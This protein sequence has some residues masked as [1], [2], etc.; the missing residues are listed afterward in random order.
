VDWY[1]WSPEAFEKAKGENKPIFLSIGYSSC[2]WCHVM[3]KEC[4]E[5]QEVAQLLNASFVCIK[6]DREERPDLDTAY[7]AVCQAMGRN[8]GWPLSILMTPRL[9]PFFA[10][11]YIPKDSRGGIVGMM[12]LLPQITQ[13]W[14]M[15]GNQ[16]DI[17]G[18]EIKSR[19]EALEK[20]TPEN[21]LGKEVLA[22]AYESLAQNYDA[23]HG[24]FG[25]APKFPRP[26]SLL[27]LLHYWKSSGTKDALDMVEKTLR[28]MRLGGIFDQVGFGFHRYSTDQVWLV[29]HFE[30][31]LYDQAL[32]AL[33]YT[34]M[35]QASGAGKFKLTA[36]ETLDYVL[37]DLASPEGGF[38]SAQ[39]A[40]VEGEEGKVYL[41]T[42]EEVM[43]TLEP[44]DADLAVHL[45]GLSAEGN[46]VDAAVGRRN[47]KNILHL[48]EP[49]DEIT[50]A[51]G[52]TLDELIIRMGK[53]RNVLFEARK[54]RVPP[55]TDVKVLTD[56]NGL[57]VAALAKA[58]KVLGENRFVEAARKTAN[59]FLAQ[60]R[61][62]NGLLYHRYAGGERAIGGF[63][64]DYAALVFGLIELYEATFEDKYLQAAAELTKKM[65]QQFWD[66]KN[67]GYYFTAA[68][69]DAGMPR[70]KQ[71]Y[72]GAV[73]SGNSM[74]LLNLL[75][76]SILINEPVFEDMARKLVKAFALEVQSA[77]E[78]YSWLLAGV[79][80]MWGP[81][82]SVVL[83]GDPKGKD[84]AEMLDALRKQYLPNIVVQLREPA[85]A[86]AGY[87][88]LE[89]KATAYV[90][91]NQTCM[92]PTNQTQKMLELLK[93]T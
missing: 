73:P 58:G 10:G 37:R 81:S 59:F 83:V 15:R 26:H 50:A 30:K 84:T 90:C 38:Y 85:K 71:I 41:W 79:S 80:F 60:M 92:P 22:E 57:M 66:D 40:D 64:D 78:A 1:P 56:W 44:A 5:D 12:E 93:T 91:L 55:A 89:G 51:K 43:D 21:E 46:Y 13:I 61:D 54:N 69:P 42:I 19:I 76:L 17:M 75:R 77:P 49:L 34:E 28:Q 24:G 9:N 3:E 18:A 4:F 8:C 36:K 2:H 88:Q 31:M 39:D 33:A 82:H 62:T 52:L 23:K 72:D 25:W 29:P 87:E 53:I 70:M 65:N 74:A 6:V 45:F 27:F 86:G 68:K 16:L 7:M 11:S 67:G 14:N 20:R 47:G 35:Y 32:L 63:L 48:A